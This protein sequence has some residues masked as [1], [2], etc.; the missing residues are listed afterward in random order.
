MSDFNPY[1]F[2]ISPPQ[3]HWGGQQDDSL[4]LVLVEPEIPGNTGNVGRLCAGANVWLHLVEPLGFELDNRYLKRAGLDYW[5]HVRLCVHRDFSKLE[6]IFPAHRM[7]F[8]SKKTQ[9]CYTTANWQPGSVL[10]FGKETKGLS[11]E[12]RQRYVDQMYRIPITDKVR[13]LNLS[14][15]CAIALYEAMRHLDFA[16]V[17]GD[18]CME[19]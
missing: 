6:E 4:H 5:P 13:S 17:Y 3:S 2:N 11:D 10:V 15:A 9:R 16:P 14:N 8:F 1:E 18:G 7:C 12:I 19:D